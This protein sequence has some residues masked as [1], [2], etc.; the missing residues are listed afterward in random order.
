MDDQM[1]QME[2]GNAH[3]DDLLDDAM[4]GDLGDE[5]LDE[6]HEEVEQVESDEPLEP[7]FDAAALGLKEINNLANFG[8]SS[9]KPGNGV[10]ELLSEDLDKYWQ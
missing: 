6:D 9:H 5:D 2:F 7:V 8:V 1:G 10:E 3:D 4:D